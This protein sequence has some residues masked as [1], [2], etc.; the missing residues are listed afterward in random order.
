MGAAVS[1]GI[2]PFACVVG[3]VCCDATDSLV[4][5]DLGEQVGQNRRVAN[6]A[7][8][9]LDGTNLQRFFIYPE[10]N[11]APHSPF[12]AAMLAG[13]PFALDLDASAFDQQVQRPLCAPEPGRGC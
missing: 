7:P 1:D 5:R 11:L 3:P 8:G 9:D 12:G 13:V 4:R 10:M 2:V 6:V